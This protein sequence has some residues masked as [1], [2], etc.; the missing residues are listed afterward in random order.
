M[1]GRAPDPENRRSVTVTLTDRGHSL[2]QAARPT[3]AER[4]RRLIAGLPDG[5]PA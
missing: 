4:A 2:V 1:I 3:Y 5:P